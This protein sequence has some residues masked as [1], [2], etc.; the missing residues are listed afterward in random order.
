[1]MRIELP[2]RMR[3]RTRSVKVGGPDGLTDRILSGCGM[4]PNVSRAGGPLVISI[5][6]VIGEFAPGATGSFRETIVKVPVIYNKSHYLLPAMAWVS[7]ERSIV[8]GAILG[9]NKAF[10]GSASWEGMCFETEPATLVDLNGINL[11]EAVPDELPD[12]QQQPFLLNPGLVVPSMGF[13]GA[14]LSRLAVEGY[15]YT[16]PPQ[17]GRDVGR[18]S[19]M[20]LGSEVR[21]LAVW[22]VSDDFTL[23]GSEPIL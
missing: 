10:C 11:K 22:E 9:F 2:N 8:R 21:A 12:E 7:S 23:T 16:A 13:R 5:S 1:M 18:W 17:I 15:H 20:V 6:E 3:S 19:G 14:G 4:P